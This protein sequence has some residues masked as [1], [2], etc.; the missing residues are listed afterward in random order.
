MTEALGSDNF[1]VIFD[2][3]GVLI[4]SYHP[5]FVSWQ[6]TAAKYGLQLTEEQFRGTFGQT[7]GSIIRQLWGDGVLTPDQMHEFDVIKE[8][9][10]RELVLAELPIMPGARELVVQ[11]S[12]GGIPVAIGSSGPPDNVQLAAEALGGSRV[13]SGFVTGKDVRQGKPDPQVFILAG[14]KLGLPPERCVVIEDAPV[15]VEAA[16]RAG[17]KSIGLQSPPPRTRDLSQASQVVDGLD[18]ISIAGI[19]SLLEL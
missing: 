7:S 17:M 6:E 18:Q 2:M 5:H 9:R 3:D 16:R 19:R 11:L 13:F 14:E 8:A 4:D 12:Q 15:G 10:Y 1:G